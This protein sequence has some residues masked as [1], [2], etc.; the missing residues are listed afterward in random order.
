MLQNEKFDNQLIFE[1]VLK[2]PL[3][4]IWHNKRWYN[5]DCLLVLDNEIFHS[6]KSNCF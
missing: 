5:F 2:F 6:K 4:Q 1:M 3:L